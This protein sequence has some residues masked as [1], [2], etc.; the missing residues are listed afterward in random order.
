MDIMIW[1]KSK[2]SCSVFEE[3]WLWLLSGRP[4]VS[5]E[6]SSGAPLYLHANI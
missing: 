5:T 3:S 4:A 2:H 1:L 6:I